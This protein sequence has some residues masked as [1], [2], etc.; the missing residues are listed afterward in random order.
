MTINMLGNVVTHMYLGLN[1]TLRSSGHPQQA[2][3][4]TIAAVVINTLLDYTFIYIF[5]WGIQGAAWATVIAQFLALLWIVKLFTD[6]REML[7]FH[8]GIY[9]LKRRIVKDTLAIGASPFL[10]NLCACLIVI[11]INK[12]LQ[13]YGGDLAIGAFGIVNRV[14]FI[15]IMIVIGLNQGMQPIAGFNF[16]AKQFD[17]MKRVVYMTIA[18]ATCITTSGFLIGE[19]FPNI[20]AR[21]FTTDAELIARSVEG[22]R[23]VFVCF[24]IIGFQMVTSHFFQSVG[25]ANK[26]IFLSLTRQLL[27]LVPCLIFLPPLLERTMGSGAIGVWMSM[28][29]SDLLATIVTVIMFRHQMKQRFA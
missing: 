10:M 20:I 27:F 2:M 16:G 21:C 15:F 19:F 1:N 17:R 3:Y 7:H 12:G 6:K 5:H 8:R 18:G 24:P 26:A 23:I 13:T 22:M 29:T 14:S 28:P 4:A 11:L 9:G 25:L